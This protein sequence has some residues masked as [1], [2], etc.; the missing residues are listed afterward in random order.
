MK[1]YAAVFALSLFG[2][3]AQP[4]CFGVE[5]FLKSQPYLALWPSLVAILLHLC[6]EFNWN[7]CVFM[8]IL[9]D[10]NSL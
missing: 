3:S 8:A 6:L 7:D 1:A 5:A 10:T 4:L 9:R 2:G